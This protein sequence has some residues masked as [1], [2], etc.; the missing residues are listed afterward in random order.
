[1]PDET[2]S[3]YSALAVEYASLWSPVIKPMG[4]RLIEMLPL[5]S[6][7]TVV[8][9]GCGT[10][11]L[12]S[13]IAESAPNARYVGL[14]R[15]SNMLGVAAACSKSLVHAD[16]C[17]LP[18]RNASFDVA[19]MAFVLFK[20]PAPVAGLTEAR[21]ILRPLGALGVSIWRGDSHALPGDEIWE[22]ILSD[23]PKG[24]GESDRLGDLNEEEKLRRVF[25]AAGFARAEISSQTFERR[26]T[27]ES[28]YVLK[29]ELTHR[30]RLA[31]LDADERERRMARARKYL[32]GL[33]PDSLVWRPSVLFAVCRVRSH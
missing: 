13:Q 27:P 23:V 22:D 26:W 21:R 20:F 8:D 32:I 33:S 10:G 25:N 11:N 5:Y 17:H 9:I 6:A 7:Q 18:L 14:D 28:L 29:T 24:P 4:L 15:A 30:A 3:R 1:M 2:Q 19:V 16:G 31:S 12:I